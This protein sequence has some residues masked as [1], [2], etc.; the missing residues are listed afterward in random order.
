MFYIVSEENYACMYEI[1]AKLDKQ[2]R[3][4]IPEVIRDLGGVGP[5]DVVKVIFVCKVES[6]TGKSEKSQNPL[7]AQVPALESILA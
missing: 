3:I 6:M 7:M 4:T 1:I 2:N 5:G